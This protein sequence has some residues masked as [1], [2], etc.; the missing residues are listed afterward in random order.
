MCLI[1][2]YYEKKKSIIYS[3]HFIGKIKTN[4][5]T[6]EFLSL[7][8]I[9]HSGH[10]R[11]FFAHIF[12]QPIEINHFNPLE[13]TSSEHSYNGGWMTCEDVAV[14]LSFSNFGIVN[15]LHSIDQFS[16]HERDTR[17]GKMKNWNNCRS[18]S[19]LFSDS[20]GL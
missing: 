19:S 2:W 20:H 11:C 5:V 3:C 7:W 8:Q 17:F 16:F 1:A 9:L 18:C 12:S 15:T 6:K 4:T 14:E 13:T 10:M